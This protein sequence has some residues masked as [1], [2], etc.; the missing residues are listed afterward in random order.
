MRRIDVHSHLLPAVDDGCK[1]VD[2]SIQC[3][4]MLVAAGYSHCFCTPHIWPGNPVETEQLVAKWTEE[5]QGALK[6]AG[7]PLR[8]L[9]GGEL[10]LHPGVMQTP[11]ERIISMGLAQRYILVDMWADELPQWFE[12]T[13]RW[14]QE[15]KLTVILGHP[16]RMRA[17]QD[18][19]E[20]AAEF[21]RL[22]VLLQGNLQC[23]ADKP[24]SYTRRTAERYLT[25][26][27]YFT[28]GSDCHNVEGLKSRLVGLCN[29]IELVGEAAVDKLT[30]H[31]PR[32]LL[33]EGFQSDP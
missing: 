7:V 31:N 29:A 5:L 1:T 24:D 19:P 13:V 11:A 2:E 15:M 22:G 17:V 20:L 27:R 14:L 28:L 23:L 18:Q 32:Q 9:P 8:L 30:C 6:S 4:R 12:P 33:P 21:A 25:E 10:N 16:E 26:G 3:A